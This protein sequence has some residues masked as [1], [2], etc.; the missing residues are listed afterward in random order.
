MIRVLRV[1]GRD[2]AGV[3]RRRH[4]LLQRQI[5]LAASQAAESGCSG[6]ATVEKLEHAVT[7]LSLTPPQ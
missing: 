6:L 3:R 5:A 7:A 2:T 4:V 1:R